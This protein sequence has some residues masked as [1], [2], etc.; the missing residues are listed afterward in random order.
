MATVT[1]YKSMYLKKQL[2]MN[3]KLVDGSVAA[4]VIMMVRV[5]CLPVRGN[6]RISWKYDDEQCVCGE[7]FHA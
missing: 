7:M 5:G 4:M 2:H 6:S 1:E 3:D